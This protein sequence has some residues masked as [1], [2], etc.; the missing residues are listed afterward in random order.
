MPQ[1]LREAQEVRE[2]AFVALVGERRQGRLRGMWVLVV[3][4][5]EEEEGEAGQR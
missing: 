1:W 3:K 2:A 5:E 4:V